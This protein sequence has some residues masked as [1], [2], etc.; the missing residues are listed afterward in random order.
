M[1][2]Q[3]LIFGSLEFL[4]AQKQLEYKKDNISHYFPLIREESNPF[5]LES[6]DISDVYGRLSLIGFDPI[7]KITGKNNSFEIALLQERGKIF[8]DEID[9]S[10]FSLIKDFKKT[11]SKISATLEEQEGVFSEE[12]H[13]KK[14]TIA[15]SLRIFLDKFK[16]DQKCFFGLYGAFA[17]DFVRLFED[18]P[19]IAEDQGDPDFC[20][21]IYDSFLYFDHLKEKAELILYRNSK[22]ECDYSLKK[23]SKNLTKSSKEK[24]GAYKITNPAF[25]LEQ[26]EYEEL[27]KK[28]KELARQGETFEVVFSRTLKADFDG[29]PF[30]LYQV[31]QEKNPSPYMFYFD[32]G[33]EFLVG[34][35]PEMMLRVEDGVCNTRPISGTMPRGKN[36]IE[37][38]E[39]MLHLLSSEKE[40]AEL[41]MLIDLARNDLARICEPGIEITEYRKVE[42]YS[43]V[44][45]T[46]AHV[47][48]NLKKNYTALDA[49]IACANA[50]T[51]TGAPK[52]QAMIEIE[53]HEKTRRG[54]YGGAVGYFS[55]SGDM[56]TAIII[57]TAHIKNKKLSLR[58]GA[59]LLY[60]SDPAFEYNETKAKSQ[61]FVD[62]F[63]QS[64]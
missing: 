52:V 37:D 23:I 15:D 45:H 28:A 64:K 43:R 54:F 1:S 53:K 31:Y 20:F 14:H 16:A 56:D 12:N 8:F 7:I 40:R 47:I 25:D 62:T 29:D 4:K 50:G 27:V 24:E 46:I 26:K 10:D 36:P 32:F 17:Y 30:A 35:S 48:G 13:T 59:T 19:N 34:A 57:R 33:D 55:F 44:M 22:L 63:A 9:E 41:D 38:H 5:I 21:Y 60:D 18:L 39:N 3:Q 51:L 49:Y 11:D 2:T 58:V 42:K 6:K 61:A